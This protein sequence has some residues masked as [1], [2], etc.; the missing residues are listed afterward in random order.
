MGHNISAIV[1]AGPWDP[2]ARARFDL[3]AVPLEQGITIFHVDHYY[4]EYWALKLGWRGTIEAPK[5]AP[6]WYP[7]EAVIAHIA[8]QLAGREDVTFGLIT[9]EYHGGEGSQW[10]GLYTRTHRLTDDRLTVNGL[11]RMLGVVAANELDEW[12]TVGLG[13]HRSAPLEL[14]RYGDL[15]DELSRK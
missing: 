5:D 11:L 14:E 10:A 9:T 6:P 4:S 2:D 1:L 13:E 3:I 12:D 7:T 15:L 8:S